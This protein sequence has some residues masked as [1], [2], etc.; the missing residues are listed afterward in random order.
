[1]LTAVWGC[2]QG[3]LPVRSGCQ[4]GFWRVCRSLQRHTGNGSNGEGSAVLWSPHCSL[5]SG[6]GTQPPPTLQGPGRFLRSFNKKN[7]CVWG[8]RTFATS[9]VLRAFWED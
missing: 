6:A 1:M 4:A 2:Y 3:S 7:T 9:W 5:G 8:Q